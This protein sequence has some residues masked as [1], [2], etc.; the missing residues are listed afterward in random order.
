MNYEEVKDKALTLLEY[1]SHS[2]AELRQKLR[3]RGADEDDIDRVTDF[4]KEYKFINDED[5][6]RRLANDL[7]K[8]KRFG[9]YRVKRELAAKGI[10]SDTI[11]IVLDGIEIDEEELLLPLVEKKLG[12]NFEKK[13][14]D[15]A[16][17]YF[18]YRGYSFDNIRHCIEYAKQNGEDYGL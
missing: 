8:L 17:R 2:E 9:L 7:I 6:A 15:K 12:G 5:Y 16:I 11:S 4:L 14:V 18:M 10:D 1:R 3:Q 13:N